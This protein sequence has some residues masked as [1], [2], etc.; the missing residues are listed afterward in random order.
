MAFNFIPGNLQWLGI[1]LETTPGTPMAAPTI[2]I[3]VD[4]PKWDPKETMLEDNNLRGFMGDTYQQIAGS[5][6]D[7]VSYKTYL[8]SDS[9]A[10][11]FKAVL[12]GTD[13]VTGSADPYTHK[14]ALYNGNGADAAQPPSY[15]VFVG[16][17]SKVKQVPGCKLSDL[18]LT[19]KANEAPTLDITW[20]GMVALDITPPTNTP[21]TQAP[22]PP[23]TAAITIGGANLGKWS[24]ITIDFKRDVKALFTLNGTQ[25]PAAIYAGTLSVTGSGTAVY[26]G[27]TD[28]DLMNYLNNTQPALTVAVNPPGDAVHT[29]TVQMS[30]VAYKSATPTPNSSGWMTLPISIKGLMNAT[31][32]TDGKMSSAQLILLNTS[33]TPL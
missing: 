10:A 12:G 29:L 24:D 4:S 28:T 23:S 7:E 9:V 3:P 19:V 20:V 27:T 5:R 15:T 1:A 18:K 30:K 21:T 13:V 26:Q 2:F 16:H 8:Y 6:Y 11:H 22:Y 32:A 25:T 31:D 14:L 33:A 17:G